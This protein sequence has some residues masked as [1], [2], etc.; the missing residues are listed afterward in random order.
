VFEYKHAAGGVDVISAQGFIEYIS[1]DQLDAFLDYVHASL[2][3]GG[4]LALGSRNRLYNLHS[5]NTFTELEA[6]LGTTDR[7]LTEA[8]I[9]QS[10][11]SVSEALSAL[12]KLN[13]MYDQPEKHP[14]TGVTVETRYQFS[15]ADLI[16]RMAKH[17]LK[18]VDIY[19]VHYHPL[20]LSLMGNPA[21]KTMHMQLAKYASDH[22]ITNYQLVPYA[23][24]FVIAASKL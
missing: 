23:S 13:Y 8:R 9:L 16:S 22:M 5:L 15:P 3:T 4:V 18:A 19:P 1:L 12:E 2:N 7:L 24:S 17:R 14:I 11:A 6:A 10:A 21:V 20:P